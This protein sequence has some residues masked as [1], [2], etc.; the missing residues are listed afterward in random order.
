MTNGNDTET[1]NSREEK[2]LRCSPTVDGRGQRRMSS[3]ELKKPPTRRSHSG[4]RSP[5]ETLPAAKSETQAEQSKTREENPR[6]E[7]K[8]NRSEI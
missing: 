6:S 4:T 2:R 7:K 3:S 1:H 8:S 5:S